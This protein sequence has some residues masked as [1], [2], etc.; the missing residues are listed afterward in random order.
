MSEKPRLLCVDDEPDV[1]DGLRLSLR[2]KYQVT[3]A[4]SGAEGLAI[5]DA[6][7]SDPEQEPFAAVVSDMRMPEMNGAEFLTQ[8]LHRSVSTPRILLSGQADLESTIAAINEAKIF[9]FLTKPCEPTLLV[10]TV[11]EA[12]E[13]QRLRDAERV[14]LDQ[15][16]RGTVSMLTEVLGLVSVTAYGRT[17][18]V[19][20]VVTQVS[21]I[22][23]RDLPWDLDVATLLSQIGCVVVP[24]DLGHGSDTPHGEMAANLLQNIPRL[25]PIAEIV[26]QQHESAPALD[27]QGMDSW[28]EHDLNAEILRAAVAYDVLL[29]RCGKKSTAMKELAEATTPPPGFIL[30]ALKEFRPSSDDLVETTATVAGLAPGMLL[31][32]DLHASS[33][34]KLA[35]EGTTLTAVLVARVR[36]FAERSGV[37]EPIAVMAPRTA[38]S[39]IRVPG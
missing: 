29:L 4:T 27:S 39:W 10:E 33:G 23:G 28:S 25:E 5:F 2:K 17:M 31:L 1:L 14:L 16:L 20:D 32:N 7:M 19:R 13:L 34:A 11:A 3:G 24:E 30:D 35:A 37:E 6:A 36:G 26:R 12:M 38:V 8:I 18:R 9:R 21:A 15:T 22:L